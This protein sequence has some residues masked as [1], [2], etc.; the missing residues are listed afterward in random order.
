MYKLFGYFI[1]L[2]P[3]YATGAIRCSQE[4]DLDQ[5][6]IYQESL[7]IEP[8]N[9]SYMYHLGRAKFCLGD[10]ETG[11]HWMGKAAS[12]GHIY[13]TYLMGVYYKTNKTIDPLLI[14]KHHIKNYTAMMFYFQKTATLIENS[15]HYPYN[16]HLDTYKAERDTHISFF[17]F[18]YLPALY[19]SGY[20]ASMKNVL[21]ALNNQNRLVLHKDSLQTLQKVLLASLRCLKRPI[22][23]IWKKQNK[24]FSNI[25]QKNCTITKNFAQEVYPLEQER[26]QKAKECDINIQHCSAYRNLTQQILRIAQYTDEQLT[27]TS[28]DLFY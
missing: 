21:P 22:L 2:I 15:Q 13:A 18:T 9:V 14:E 12:N 5:S 28:L 4:K 11:A 25:M 17:V 3:F 19:F 6:K 24:K 7:E 10:L 27:L 26:L 1:C 20:Y 16:T 23:T 8:D